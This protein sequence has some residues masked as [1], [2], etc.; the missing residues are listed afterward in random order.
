MTE[1]THPLARLKDAA[2]AWIKTT[3]GAMLGEVFRLSMRVDCR[4]MVDD[5]RLRPEDT[6]EDLRYEIAEWSST[7]TTKASLVEILGRAS[8]LDGGR[9]LL[10]AEHQKAPGKILVLR[11]KMRVIDRRGTGSDGGR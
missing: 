11:E 8:S 10:E 1:P 2:L 5:I 3:P 9:A 7:E 6:P 4:G